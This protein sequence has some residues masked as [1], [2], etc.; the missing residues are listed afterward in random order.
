LGSPTDTIQALDE[1]VFDDAKVEK[2]T[3]IAKNMLKKF[4]NNDFIR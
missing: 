3:V 2:I 1:A 4:F